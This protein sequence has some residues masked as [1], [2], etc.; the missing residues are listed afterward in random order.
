LLD[1]RAQ[2]TRRMAKGFGPAQVKTFDKYVVIEL[3]TSECGTLKCEWCQIFDSHHTFYIICAV[4]LTTLSVPVL[5]DLCNRCVPKVQ[6]KSQLSILT[7]ELKP[8]LLVHWNLIGPSVTV[9]LPVLSP[10]S[11]LPPPSSHCVVSPARKSARLKICQ[12]VVT[13]KCS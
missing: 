10:S 3:W 8:Y 13:L 6:R 2:A 4:R 7:V 1:R 11:I 5:P 12:N 9:T